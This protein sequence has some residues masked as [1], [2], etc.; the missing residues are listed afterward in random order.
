MPNDINSLSRSADILESAFERSKPTEVP[1][2]DP[3]ARLNQ[4]DQLIVRFETLDNGVF[5]QYLQPLYN[6]QSMLIEQLKVTDRF[7]W[8]KKLGRR[9]RFWLSESDLTTQGDGT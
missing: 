9:W 2:E 7:R 4:I 3:Q 5:D 1:K 8:L 6:E